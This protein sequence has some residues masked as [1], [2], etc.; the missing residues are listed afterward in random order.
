[1]KY[2]QGII[3]L[4]IGTALGGSVIAA[5]TENSAPT[6]DI[7]AQVLQ[8]I[9]EEPQAIV[10]SLNA[11]QAKQQEEKMA[12]AS[13]ALKDPATN[14]AVH[15]T[16]DSAFIGKADS[17]NTVVEFFDYNCPACKMQFE[18]LDALHKADGDVKIIFKEYPIFGAQSEANSR[19]GIAVNRIAPDKYFAWHTK[20]MTNKGRTDEATALKY[21][22]EV[23]IDTAKLKEEAA[24]PKVAEILAAERALGQKLNL[25]GTPSLI[26]GDELV[27]H[28]MG[29]DEIKSKFAN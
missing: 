21:A 8:V 26:I 23:G 12:G 7:R 2:A 1:M 19:I 5:T 3:G 22:Q 14:A 10:D 24:S 20:M 25:Q 28:A 11:W 6:G 27:P 16:A 15:D 13:A 9:K 4:L 17:K 29:A 18:Q